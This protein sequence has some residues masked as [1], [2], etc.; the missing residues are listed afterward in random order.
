M[1]G[2]RENPVNRCEE[3]GQ[4]KT[5]SSMNFPKDPIKKKPCR[6]FQKSTNLY[7]GFYNK[8]IKKQGNNWCW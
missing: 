8:I 6:I 1:I 2:K 3:K 4:G 7:F 5:R